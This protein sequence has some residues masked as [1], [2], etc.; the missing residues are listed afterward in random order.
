MSAIREYPFRTWRPA[1][2]EAVRR[3]AQSAL[4]AGCVL[5][6]PQLAFEVA[7]D[8]R[9][10]LSP[11]W[12]DGKS[13]NVSLRSAGARLRGA[14]GTAAELAG[15][16]AMTQRFADS[17][18]TLV[19]ALFPGYVARLSRART[20]FRP[21]PA[22]DR[23]LSW[24][25]DD[26]RMHV[27]AFP[28]N[29]LHGRRIFRVFSNINPAGMPRVWRIGEPFEEMA[30]RFLPAV[31]KQ[32]RALALLMAAVGITKARRSEYDHVMLHL[33]DLA[34]A[35][36]DYQRTSCREEF[37]FPAGS[38][39]VCF[40][41]QVMHAATDGQ[42]MLEQTSYLPVTALGEPATSPLRVL[43]RLAGHPLV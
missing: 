8:E 22:A 17:S 11:K 31:P 4:E 41:D 13:K 21:A 2:E 25:K 35:D 37:R 40:S 19:A 24:R 36:L 20:S 29:P 43:E 26:T 15:L 14:V 27:D 10:Y 12:S 39:W 5:F 7:P 38:T 3:E 28:S 42:Y 9:Q 32:S 30:R 33:H 1:I 23:E 16:S 18:A 6:F 34:K